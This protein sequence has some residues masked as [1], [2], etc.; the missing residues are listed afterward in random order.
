MCRIVIDEMPKKK[1]EKISARAGY[2][3]VDC[4][5]YKNGNCIFNDTPCS[6]HSEFGNYCK[7]EDRFMLI[8]EIK[9]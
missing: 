4:P 9:K 1:R 5:F 6:F 3:W 2:T 8:K 7:F